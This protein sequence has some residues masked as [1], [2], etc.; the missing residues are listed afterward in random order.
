MTVPVVGLYFKKVFSI[1]DIFFLNTTFVFWEHCIV[2]NN[3]IYRQAKVY[4]LIT[5][6]NL[7]LTV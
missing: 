4:S 5:W 2:G 6:E 7:G 3:T 1:A